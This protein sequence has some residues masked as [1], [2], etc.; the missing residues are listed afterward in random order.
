MTYLGEVDVVVV[1]VVKVLIY[2]VRRDL[3]REVEHSVATLVG[4]GTDAERALGLTHLGS[5]GRHRL[6]SQREQIDS[7]LSSLFVLTWLAEEE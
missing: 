1:S 4:H 7:C 6:L 2:G 3:L 5:R